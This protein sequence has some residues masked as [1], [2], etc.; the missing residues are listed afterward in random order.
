MSTWMFLKHPLSDGRKTLYLPG[1]ENQHLKCHQV[2]IAP[3]I[4]N[5][6]KTERNTPVNKQKINKYFSRIA[7][8]TPP[9]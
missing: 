3:K 4:Y 8:G 6:K 7:A 2:P 1:K 9:M 5:Q